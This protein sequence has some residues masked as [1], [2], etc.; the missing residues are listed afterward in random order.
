[1]GYTCLLAESP[2]KLDA[3]QS[4]SVTNILH[5]TQ[6]AADLVRS[7]RSLSH[8]DSTES[9]SFD[10]F[11]VASEVVQVLRA[12]TDRMIG[13]ELHVKSGHCPIRG[14]ASNVYHALMNLG[15]NA[16]QA[17]EQKGVT[18]EDRVAIDADL[19]DVGDERPL[20][21]APG[22]Y[23]HITVSDTGIGMTDEVRH[24]AFEPLFSTKEKGERK[25]QGFGLAM[26]YNIV[27]RQHG[28]AV[29][30]E[31]SIGQGCHFHL[32]LPSAEQLTVAA[33]SLKPGTPSGHERIL[34][35]EDEPQ[36][37]RL[38]RTVLERLGYGVLVAADGREAI[39]L[40]EREHDNIDL[41][42]LD[43]T[44]P[45]QR[46]EQVFEHLRALRPDIPVIVSSGDVSV[47]IE[48]FPGAH[49]ILQK[50]YLPTVLGSVVR[51]ALDLEANRT[52]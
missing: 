35:V 52:H 41:V 38:A 17:I 30:I 45:G 7:L 22:R 51:E 40:F 32:Y 31:R 23:V 48:A 28:G 12:T 44:L 13:K 19:C 2:L 43:R 49:F 24:H 5:A 25:G 9:D 50:P 36:L 26:V 16:V 20:G 4:E 8:P 11:D 6:R 21:L 42:L 3:V 18:D 37:A 14:S 33:P 47:G 1:M 15:V 10:L 46:G 39:D 27:V 29:D 34:V